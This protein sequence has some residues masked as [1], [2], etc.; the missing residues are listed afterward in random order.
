MQ[1]YIAIA[2]LGPSALR[3]QGSKGVIKAAEKHL[4]DIDLQVFRAIHFQ[5][6]VGRPSDAFDFKDS[7]STCYGDLLSIRNC[8]DCGAFWTNVRGKMLP[9][10]GF[11]LDLAYVL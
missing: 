4:A 3:N 7:T 2:T 5:N 6:A 1:K 9:K 8:G 11:L 10:P